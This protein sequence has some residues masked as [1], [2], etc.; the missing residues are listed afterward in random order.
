LNGSSNR[1]G[2]SATSKL[3]SLA[4]NK[5]TIIVWDADRLSTEQKEQTKVID[6]FL[7]Q[8]KIL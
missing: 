7:R 2:L 6:N 5:H 4:P 8:G 1:A 3:N